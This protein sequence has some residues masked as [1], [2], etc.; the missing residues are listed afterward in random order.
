MPRL[1]RHVRRGMV[2]IWR[3]GRSIQTTRTLWRRGMPCCTPSNRMTGPTGRATACATSAPTR[4]TAAPL[5]DIVQ[6]AAGER[7]GRVVGIGVM[8]VPLRDNL[9]SAEVTVA[10]HPEHRRLGAG[11]AIVARM[12]ELAAAEGR[13][14]L[15]SIVDV[16]VAKAETHPGCPSPAASVSRPPC[17]ATVATSR[18]PWTRAGPTSCAPWC[19]VHVMPMA[20]GRSPGCR[21]GRRSSSRTTAS[22]SAACPPTSRR[23]TRTRRRRCGTPRASVKR[24]SCWR[25]GASGSSR[26]WPSTS[27]TGRLVALQR[28]LVGARRADRGLAD[29]HARPPGAPRAPSRPG[30]EAGQCRGTGGGGAR[31]AAHRDR[32]RGR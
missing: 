8:E 12:A 17:P 23:A 5:G 2:S 21:R 9:H 14:S 25:L 30:R 3:S 32:Q 4:G 10:V 6:L 24:T 7:G 16:P 26:P 29:G 31:G 20:T 19:E 1:T 28:A 13:R 15:N 22:C 11:S 18:C 27:D